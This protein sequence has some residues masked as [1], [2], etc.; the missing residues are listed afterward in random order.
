MPIGSIYYWCT[1][2]VRF[3][4]SSH[5]ASYQRALGDLQVLVQ[6]V[7][8]AKSEAHAKRGT[9][10]AGYLK[11]LPVFMLVFPGKRTCCRTVQVAGLAEF[12]STK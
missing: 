12:K 6:R 9:V 3:Q 5:R 11:I 7:L 4:F 8:S 10:L 1:D 2:Q